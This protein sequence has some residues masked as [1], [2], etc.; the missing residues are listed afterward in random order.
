MHLQTTLAYCLVLC[1]LQNLQVLFT[2]MYYHLPQVICSQSSSRD[3]LFTLSV[4]MNLKCVSCD[5]LSTNYMH[6][7]LVR[8]ML[9]PVE[10]RE[11]ANL[12]YSTS[13]VICWPSDYLS[14]SKLTW[15]ECQIKS[16]TL[17]PWP[18]LSKPPF[19]WITI[20]PSLHVN[21]S[22]QG[23]CAEKR[24]GGEKVGHFNLV[25]EAL[26]STT[27]KKKKTGRERERER[28]M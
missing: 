7:E 27:E 9:I 25:W 17:L 1:R 6:H 19:R 15:V 8:S 5:H 18:P 16:F 20:C 13:E 11:Y 23:G 12:N 26:S 21:K 10:E 4:N 24:V 3:T 28:E 2:R 22:T 14:N